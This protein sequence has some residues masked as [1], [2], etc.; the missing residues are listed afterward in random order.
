MLLTGFNGEAKSGI[1][2]SAFKISLDSDCC[3]KLVGG[4]CKGT[5]SIGAFT[6]VTSSVVAGYITGVFSSLG[7]SNVSDLYRGFCSGSAS[8]ILPTSN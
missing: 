2:R 4:S 1:P 6:G 8:G 7:A 5:F 3:S